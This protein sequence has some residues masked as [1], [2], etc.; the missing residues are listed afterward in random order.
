ML[1]SIVHLQARN[2]L[3][4]CIFFLHFALS[5][6][7]EHILVNTV[8]DEVK[9]LFGLEKNLRKL[10]VR[11]TKSIFLK[12]SDNEPLKQCLFECFSGIMR[13]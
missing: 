12:I 3:K 13:G 6:S 1:L 10:T 4:T 8:E 9:R 2:L 11:L 5:N 7:L